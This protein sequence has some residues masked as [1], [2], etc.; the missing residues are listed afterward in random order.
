MR[1]FVFKGFQILGIFAIMLIAVS[2][3]KD[4]LDLDSKT[5]LRDGDDKAIDRLRCLELI[6]PVTI[7]FPDGGTQEVDDTKE[8]H[9][10]LRQW[11][12]DH[13]DSDVRPALEYPVE[14]KYK[15]GEIYTV[16]SEEQMARFKKR[17]KG[18]RPTDGDRDKRPCFK[19]VF[20]VTIIFP[21][22]TTV[23]VTDRKEWHLVIK[24][25]K[26]NHPDSD[27]RPSLQYPV[28]IEFRGGHIYTLTSDEDMAKA[29]KRCK[30]DRPGGDTD[31]D[32]D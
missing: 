32:R 14:I 26:E 3:Q 15:D 29:K 12:E 16:E 4:A 6:Y 1:T 7:I 5:E 20:P 18:D 17:C 28:D 31:G 22:G 19:I 27:A 30:D 21:D 24:E 25:W 13:P 10:A 11:K 2:C 9:E 8:W 23:E